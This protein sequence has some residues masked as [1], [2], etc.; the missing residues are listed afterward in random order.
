[1]KI[2]LDSLTFRLVAGA[3]LWIIVVL[4]V[5]GIALSAVFRST[6]EK[7]FDQGLSAQIDTLI[8]AVRIH[9]DGAISLTRILNDK[10]FDIPYSGWYWQISAPWYGTVLRSRSLWDHELGDAPEESGDQG[11]YQDMGD[12]YGK[13]RSFVKRVTFPGFRRPMS[14]MITGNVM[15]IEREIAHF[16][17]MLFFFLGILAAGVILAVIVQV[18]FGLRPLRRIERDLARV[19]R[20]ENSR[21][22]GRFPAEV[23]SMVQEINSLI[24]Y[25]AKVLDRARHHVGNLVHALRTPLSVLI[26]EASSS[27]GKLG[28]LVRR[29]SAIMQRYVDHH[30][31]RARSAGQFG[32]PGM[33]TPV[34]PMIDDVKRVLAKLHPQC[35]IAADIQHDHLC[36]R[37]ERGDLE[38]MIGNLLENACKWARSKVELRAF[39]RASSLMI[40][41][42]DDGP[43]LSVSQRRQVFARGARLDEKMPGSGLGLSIVHDYVEL[44]GGSIRLDKAEIGGLKVVLSLPGVLSEWQKEHRTKDGSAG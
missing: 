22:Q 23:A 42:E 27:K 31:S 28:T 17:T 20:G 32:M 11:E 38:E 16:N 13:V 44:Y 37:G 25:N 18:Y 4:V 21:L 24:D 10:R 36:F 3:G 39:L 30:L 41:I 40:V 19:R 33:R 8:A 5:G 34:K 12:S 14:F 15:D 26:N 7:A 6:V 35:R 2:R 43:G 1:M 29:Q 9:D